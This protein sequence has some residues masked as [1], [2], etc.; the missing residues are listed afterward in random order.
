VQQKYYS[1]AVFAVEQAK[2]IKINLHKD[3][4]SNLGQGSEVMFYYMKGGE[5]PVKQINFTIFDKFLRSI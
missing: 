1:L 3:L 2:A 4:I 5:G